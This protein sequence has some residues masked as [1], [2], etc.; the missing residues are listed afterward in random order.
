MKKI[1]KA[2]ICSV[3]LVVMAMSV[4]AC[5][6]NDDLQ[7][8]DSYRLTVQDPHRYIIEN[9]QESYKAGDKVT[10]KTEI[11]HDASIVAFLDGVSLG[12]EK[13]VKT[14]NNYT[15]WEFYFVMPAHDSVLSLEFRDGF[16]PSES[17]IH[18]EIKAAYIAKHPSYNLTDADISLHYYGEFDGTYVLIIRA[19]CFEVANVEIYQ[20][21]DD[22]T[23]CFSVDESFETYR[24]GEF[25]SLQK[26]FDLGFLS[27][28]NLYSVWE[29]HR[30]ENYYL[31]RSGC[32]KL[33]VATTKEIVTAYVANHSTENHHVTEDD[34][35]LRC[36]GAFDGAYVLFV[37]E[38]NV[39][40]AAVICYE[41][42]SDVEFI[43]SSSHSLTV[44]FEGVFYSVAKAFE[45][46]LLTHDDLVTAQ[47]NY[48]VGHEYLYH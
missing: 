28:D 42:V 10:V 39:G 15:H 21:V 33:N 20:T 31:Y 1:L 35:G 30:A 34:I 11:L 44:Y 4:A 12:A 6:G 22:I 25:Y 24:A 29:K 46:G 41:T 5:A 7:D 32:V 16:L 45:K 38:A 9:L 48:R 17:E 27:H 2:L 3:L 36:F 37:D 40:Y 47:K 19:S 43:Y 8:A 13:P 26:A 14:G 18:R 23:Y